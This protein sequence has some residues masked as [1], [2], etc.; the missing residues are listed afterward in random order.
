MTEDS[1]STAPA[2]NRDWLLTS[3]RLLVTVI[4]ALTIVVGVALTAAAVAA[5]IMQNE[6]LLEINEHVNQ[7]VGTGV[8]A[9][10][11]GFMLATVAFMVIGFLWLRELRRIIDSVGLGDPFNPANAERLARMG[12]LTVIVE[13]LSIP[14]GALAAYPPV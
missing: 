2:A 13:A 12:W 14:G 10:I 5:P 11:V 9:V 8:I 7:P 3:A 6:L 1:P 4:M